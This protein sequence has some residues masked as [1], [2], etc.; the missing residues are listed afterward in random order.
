MNTEQKIIKNKVGLLKLSEMHLLRKREHDVEIVFTE[1][2]LVGSAP[3]K[4]HSVGL[5][6]RQ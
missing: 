4:S 3:G 1:M 2:G 5:R 6:L